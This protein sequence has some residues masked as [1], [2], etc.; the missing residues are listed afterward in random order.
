MQTKDP[1]K[2]RQEVETFLKKLKFKIDIFGIIYID[3]RH[4]NAQAL[5]TL[6]IS[7]SRRTEILKELKT[8][9]YAEG[10]IEEK[11][12]G[13]AQMWI[14]GKTIKEKEVYIKVSMGQLNNSAVCISFHIAEH[15][16]TY[17]LKKIRL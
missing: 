3:E 17:P 14:F 1:M 16:M 10:P 9:D 5:L 7:P 6:D 11:M 2:D 12:R 15:P 13:F 8:E 4:K